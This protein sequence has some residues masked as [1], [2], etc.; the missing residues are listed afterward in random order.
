MPEPMFL[1]ADTLVA[2]PEAEARILA[3]WKDR[4][5]FEKS[6]EQRKGCPPF[7]FYEGPPTANGLPHNGH[8]LTRVIKD[9][10]PRYRAMRGYYVP[11]KAGWDTHGLPVEV[12]VEKELGIHGKA[13]IEEYG[14]EAFVKRCIE[15][16]FRYTNEWER[17]TERIG[18]WVDLSEA[19]VTF[20][21]SYIESVWWALSELFKAG[22]LYRGHKVIW[23][24]PQGGTA[25]SSAEV[26]L[27][28]KTVDDPSV[29]VAFPFT[30]DP[31]SALLIW[32]TTP[33][34][35][36]S[37]MYAAVGPDVDYV[38][39]QSASRKL[40]LA[41]ALR[42][43]ISQKT[44]E[45]L[46]V[47]RSFKGKELLG[48]TYRPPFDIYWDHYAAKTADFAAGGSTPLFW[49]VLPAD[50]VELDA[51]T[52]IV[53]IASAFGEVD[54]DL[55]RA[56]V[57]TYK[58]PLSV[59]LLC[60]VAPDGS[61]NADF[62]KYQGIW[63][64]DADRDLVH[65]LRERGVLVH[66]ETYRHEYPFC[67]RA[68]DDP[69]IQM[70][71]PTWFIRTTALL[72]KAKANN[73][74]FHWLPDHI[75]D[76]RFGDFLN[77]NVDWALS[78]ERYWGTPL[79][80]W[81]NDVSGKMMAPSSVNEIL[82]Y[83]PRAFDHW[84]EAK[85]SDP[86]LSDHLMVHKPW[87]DKVTFAVEGEEGVYRRVTEVIDCW[88]D[89]GAMPFAQ[90][91]FPHTGHEEFKQAFPAD[92]ISE[93]IDQTRGWFYSQMMI[94][95]L[96]FQKETQE[97]LGLEPQTYPLPFKTC[98]VL[99]HVTDAEG[100]KESKSKGNYTPPE[101]ILERVAMDFAVVDGTPLGLQAEPATALIAREDLEGLDLNPGATVRLTCSATEGVAIDV[102]L[103]P[104]KKLP[105]RVVVLDAATQLQLGVHPNAKGLQVM[106][107]EVPRV[108][109]RERIRVENAS[110]PAPGADAFRWFFLASNP[111]WNSTRHSLSNVRGLQKEFPLKLRNVY[112]FFTIYANIDGYSPKVH[113]GRPVAER[114]LLDRWILSELSRV[115]DVVTRLMDHYASYEATQEL[116]SF[117]E[118]L[119]NWWLRRSRD[120]FWTGEFTDSK[121]DAYSTLYECL[122]TLI[123]L[124]APFTPFQTEELYQNLVVRAYGGDMPVSVHLCNYPVADLARIDQALLDE[125]SLVRDIVT[126]GLRV[127]NDHKLKV[128]Q[129]LAEAKVV[130]STG[131]LRQR[132]AAYASLIADELNVK[133][134]HFLESAD[135]FVNYKAKPNF[136]RLGARVGKQMPAVKRAL[137][138]VDVA[139][140]RQSLLASGTATV[141]VN[142]EVLAL[143]AEDIEIQIVEKQGFAAAG[144]S[145]TV[146]IL[147]TQ[148]TPEL[149]D[150][151]LYRD[152]LNRVQTLRKELELEY[153][154]RVGL[155][156]CGSER[157]QRVLAERREHFMTETLCVDLSTAG[158]WN[159]EA[160]LREYELDG[161]T[162]KVALRKQ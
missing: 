127:R 116:S 10:F 159:G 59:P 133:E 15:S 28:Y 88:F 56:L 6:L 16:V 78:R 145:S 13:A 141:E 106:P 124:A 160:P 11:R 82:S 122:T 55:H 67:W 41:A 121:R 51:G 134:V 150:E 52:G 123:Q 85:A 48:R 95:T 135:E 72:E 75:K 107:V 21:K 19:Y 130:V 80:V 143:D 4:R 90:W 131:N 128:R 117:V 37:N 66:R 138:T 35:L 114:A 125:M 93:A 49:K 69:L 27:N 139:A 57:Q 9:L 23:W 147:R 54:H 45:E 63:V 64:K 153:T 109:A 76:G 91:G 103:I 47:L 39:V 12:E 29:Y 126:L 33:W 71:R 2:F 20:H 1:K 158:E 156:L 58:D 111:P 83:N 161:E 5:I 32:T 24:W 155:V 79:N 108:P 151:G 86:T 144:D 17:L 42:E 102:S 118:S 87:I 65:D 98:I 40:V 94:A 112:S 152:V 97:R 62:P 50:F 18:F 25:L 162:L 99:G 142:G 31:A 46:P 60:A 105:R 110:M 3:F 14:V 148:L 120:R 81:V 101:V 113:G 154:Q 68:D 137:E 34:T 44:G 89:S 119:S 104:A 149:L 92:F 74:A 53:H 77:N 84:Q 100:K 146:L 115:T 43:Q 26:G 73:Q 136:R 7:V 30:D 129:P 36:P 132:V 22:L 61:F 96:V 70:A 8:V 140:L 38:E 157:L